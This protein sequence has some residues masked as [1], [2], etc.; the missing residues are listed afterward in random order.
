MSF[1]AINSCTAII[2]AGG[3]ASRMGTDKR[4]LRVGSETLL[5]RQVRMLKIH[6]REILISA[7][8]P[9]KLAYLNLP[10]VEDDQTGLGPLGGLTTALAA[11]N[12][13]YN[14]VIAVD[15]PHIDMNLVKKM[16]AH[17]TNVSAVIPVHVDGHLEPLFA[18]YGKSCVPIFKTA[19]SE[20]EKAIHRALEKCLFYPFPLSR[21]NQIKN[22]N[23]PSDF[24][25]FLEENA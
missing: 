4:F 25:I 13:A 12:S 22:I 1:S 7:N 6:F 16:L 15:I 14:F 11:S 2:L 10:I 9:E 8:D 18:I 19:I 5:E 17:S 23:S 20:G 24:E 21:Q 3:S